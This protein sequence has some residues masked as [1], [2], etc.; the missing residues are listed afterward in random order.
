[1]CLFFE[2]ERILRG[3]MIFEYP[4]RRTAHPKKSCK[5][6]AVTISQ[7]GS[8][9]MAKDMFIVRYASSHHPCRTP[10]TTRIK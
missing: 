10:I 8:I 1:M 5:N 4:Q 7:F 6:L 2:G 3:R 9:K